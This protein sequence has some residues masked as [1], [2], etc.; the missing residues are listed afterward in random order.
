[1]AAYTPADLAAHLQSDV[2]TATAL[3]C[4]RVAADLAHT[5]TRGAGFDPVTGVPG[6]D[7]AAVVLMA[8]GRMYV[9]PGH[10]VSEQIGGVATRYGVFAGWSLPE[11]TVLNSYRRRAA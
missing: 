1:M 2:D 4:L 3:L 6:D 11:L 10:A 5:Y 9:N 7:V 8:A